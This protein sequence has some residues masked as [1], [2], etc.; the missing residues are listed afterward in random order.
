M[1]EDEK[2]PEG[3]HL[4]LNLSDKVSV[5][6]VPTKKLT[7]SDLEKIEQSMIF[8][9]NNL[10]KTLKSAKDV[11]K[12]MGFQHLSVSLQSSIDTIQVYLD[13]YELEKKKEK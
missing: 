2:K 5:S 4:E 9:L 8:F 7:K 11:V 13:Q 1:S 10:Q 6:E 3:K 12:R